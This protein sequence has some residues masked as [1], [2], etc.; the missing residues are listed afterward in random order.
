MFLNRIV[1]SSGLCDVEREYVS[2]KYCPILKVYSLD[3]NVHNT[4]WTCGIPQRFG[5]GPIILVVSLNPGFRT[6]LNTDLY[7]VGFGSVVGSGS[8]QFQLA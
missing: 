5:T 7:P 1:L 8:C 6:G 4:S 3:T 2:N